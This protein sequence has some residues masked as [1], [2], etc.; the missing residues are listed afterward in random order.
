MTLLYAAY[1]WLLIQKNKQIWQHNVFT[2]LLY[3]QM[4]LPGV[5]NTCMEKK[6][7]LQPWSSFWKTKQFNKWCNAGKVS[8]WK[9][10][11]L[12]WCWDEYEMFHL[13]SFSLFLLCQ[14]RSCRSGR[15][16]PGPAPPTCAENGSS[17]PLPM[18]R[19]TGSTGGAGTQRCWGACLWPVRT[20]REET[21]SD[22]P[23]LITRTPWAQPGGTWRELSESRRV[24]TF[25]GTAFPSRSCR[26]RS[27]WAEVQLWNQLRT[28]RCSCR[29]T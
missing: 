4:C 8:V 10:Q 22:T 25:P 24:H 12:K 27:F 19:T 13:Y 16:T 6:K 26:K 11:H 9:A 3:F 5:L 7:A 28:H 29:V 1:L 2:V 21:S 18:T 23:R 15:R 20:H 14:L 17:P